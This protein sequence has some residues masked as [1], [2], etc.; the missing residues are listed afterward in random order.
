MIP[1]LAATIFAGAA[2]AGLV[3][4]GN[5]ADAVAAP[6]PF[7]QWCPGEFWDPGW[8]NNWDWNNCHD[9]RGGPPD[10]PGDRGP[11][12]GGPPPPPDRP[13]G[14]PPPPGWHP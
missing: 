13:W 1:R 9:W 3:G 12:W 4:V 5:A 7:P 8:G 6:G 10:R 14:P 11:G 2:V